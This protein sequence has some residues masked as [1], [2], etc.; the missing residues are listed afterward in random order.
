[1]KVLVVIHGYPPTAVAGTELC[2]Q[3]LCVALRERGHEIFVFTREERLG[4]PEYKIMNDERDGIPIVR[5]V[6]NFTKLRK[7][8]YYEYHP[9]VEEIFERY[10]LRIEPDLVHVQHLAGA[11]WG[12][13]KIVKKHGVPLVISLH[14]YW[15]PCERVQLLRPEGRIC[16]DPDG[17]RNCALYCAHGSL[18]LLASAVMERTRFAFGL[19]D[20]FP[21]ERLALKTAAAFQRLAMRRKT[22]R[23]ARVYGRRC[24][25]LMGGLRTADLLISPSEKARSIYTGLGVPDSRHMVIP[26]GMPE[27]KVRELAFEE[28]DYDGARPLIVGYIGNIMAHKGVALL[29]KAVKKFPPSKIQLKMYGRSYPPRYARIIKKVAGRFHAGQLEIHGVYRPD[30]LPKILAG[31]DLLVIP[32][33]WHETFN[34]VLWEAWAAG[35]PVIV[36][37]VGA[38]V[39][40]VREGVDG[41]TLAP[42]DWR[43]LYK[44]LSQVLGEPSLLQRLRKGI[45]RRCISLDE[46]AER[47][48]EAFLA[49][50]SKAQDVH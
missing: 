32:S 5:I 17:G 10:L 37:R 23:L 21:G 28:E 1:L 25:R 34:L 30:D 33:L 50:I 31:L 13:P 39:D 2:A 45:T 48:E 38:M 9:R 14:D 8:Y 12:I 7:D 43:D 15:Y 41:L 47:Y 22:R 44:K 18:S 35:L 46:N 19:L 16:P 11:S 27:I 26:H 20:R 36:S 42:G 49:L 24:E 6:N 40:F 29:L 3:R 4:Y